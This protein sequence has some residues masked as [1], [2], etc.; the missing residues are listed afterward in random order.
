MPR[1]TVFAMGLVAQRRIVEAENRLAKLPRAEHLVNGKLW[2]RAVAKMEARRKDAIETG[3]ETAG[4]TAVSR[5][6]ARARPVSAVAAPL[7]RAQKVADAAQEE[8]D[9]A[10]P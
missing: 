2:D 10:M 9:P 1:A 8:V 4:E 5:R 6:P 3:G 7:A